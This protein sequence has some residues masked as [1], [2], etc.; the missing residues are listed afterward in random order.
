MASDV[1]RDLVNLLKWTH[2]RTHYM[3]HYWSHY[4]SHHH[5]AAQMLLRN[6][7]EKHIDPVARELRKRRHLNFV[8]NQL[9]V[10]DI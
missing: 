9:T 8:N 7:S 2:C 6:K 10:L 1:M 5:P 4:M 3:S